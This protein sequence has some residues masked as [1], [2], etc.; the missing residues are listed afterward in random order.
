[1][2]KSYVGGACNPASNGDA[3]KIAAAQV[4]NRSNQIK[5][6]LPVYTTFKDCQT[7][8]DPHGYHFSKKK[9]LFA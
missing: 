1:L 3:R 8:V 7:F 6:S 5:F 2:E 9:F 4:K